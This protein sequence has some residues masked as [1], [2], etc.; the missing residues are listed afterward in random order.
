MFKT[1]QVSATCQ[2]DPWKMILLCT[3]TYFTQ[4]YRYLIKYNWDKMQRILELIYVELMSICSKS[5]PA[6]STTNRAMPDHKTELPI[7]H[8]R[9]P[10]PYPMLEKSECGHNESKSSIW[11]WV[12]YRRCT[13]IW[14]TTLIK[15]VHK[16]ISYL[17]K[18]VEW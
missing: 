6:I 11:A 14:N 16:K 5:T 3:C 1:K 17:L 10:T 9:F 15:E 2:C 18:Q 7:R 8:P 12:I 13:L 4:M